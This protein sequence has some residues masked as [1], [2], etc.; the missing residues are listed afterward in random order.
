MAVSDEASSPSSYPF[1]IEEASNWEHSEADI[2]SDYRSTGWT[3]SG[4][5]PFCTNCVKETMAA[6]L[7][8]RLQLFSL[9][10]RLASFLFS[11][12]SFL[13]WRLPGPRWCLFPPTGLGE[14]GGT[15]GNARRPISTLPFPDTGCGPREE[16]SAL[17]CP[18]HQARRTSGLAS[19]ATGRSVQLF[20]ILR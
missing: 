3:W 14:D 10:K 7:R 9:L 13:R 18:S 16:V 6:R 2:A 4:L 11:S 1:L 20:S 8:P 5:S 17:G 19:Q 12:N 15:E